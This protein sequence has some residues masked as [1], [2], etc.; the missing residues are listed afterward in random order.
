MIHLLRGILLSVSSLAPP[1][2]F[3]VLPANNRYP[4][5]VSLLPLPAPPN[6]LPH[7]HLA[8]HFLRLAPPLVFLYATYT[9]YLPASLYI[10][11]SQFFIAM[12]NNQ[13]W[14]PFF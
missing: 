8:R 14:S 3:P 9:P 5:N 2:A 10:P 11:L 12:R 7:T 4:A 1:S 13:F 6:T